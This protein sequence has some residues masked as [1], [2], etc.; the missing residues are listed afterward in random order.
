MEVNVYA[1]L[2]SHSWVK[3]TRGEFNILVGVNK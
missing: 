1:K 3:L 2:Q